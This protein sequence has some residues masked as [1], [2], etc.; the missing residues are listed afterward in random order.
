MKAKSYSKLVSRNALEV[1]G[2]VT[3]YYGYT[4]A[5]TRD[6]FERSDWSKGGFGIPAGL[7]GGEYIL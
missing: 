1:L 3:G 6:D 5:F 2:A 7:L 4:C